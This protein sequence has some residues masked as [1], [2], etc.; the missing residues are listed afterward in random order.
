MRG[1]GAIRIAKEVSGN[2]RVE[3]PLSSGEYFRLLVGWYPSAILP[4]LHGGRMLMAEGASQ[5]ADSAEARNDSLCLSHTPLYV[6]CVW[7]STWIS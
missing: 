3:Q 4:A 7:R 1:S 5:G 2:E 6:F